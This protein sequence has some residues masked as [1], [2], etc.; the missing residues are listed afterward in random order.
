MSRSATVTQVD[1]EKA[2]DSI[3]W[4]FLFHALKKF[5][6]GEK[7]INWIKILYTD[8]QSCVGN[9]GFFSPFF[10]LTR[11]IRQGCPISALLFLLV[12]EVLAI[13]IRSDNNIKGIKINDVELKLS[14]MADD[15]TLFLADI[16][17]LTL[18]IHKFIEF[19]KCSGLKLNLNK[20]EIIPIGKSRKKDITLPDE[21]TTIQINHGPFKAL[22]IWYSYDQEEILKLNVDKRL[23]SMN[24]I[25][26]IWRSRNLSLKGK[27]T[28][29]KTLIIPQIHFLFAMIYIPDKI[30]QK[31]D[32]LLFDFLWNSKPAKIKR[33]TI[34]APIGEGGMGMV[35]V[36]IVHIASKIS[37]I[38]RLYDSTYGKWKIVMLKSM[39]TELNILNKKCDLNRNQNITKFY[40][41]VLKSWYEL[42]NYIPNSPN[43]ILNEYVLHNKSIKIGGKVIDKKYINSP[44]LKIIDITEKNG[45]KTL[46]QLNSTL[47]NN[48]TQMKYN[49]IISA[50][51][52]LWKRTIKNINDEDQLNIAIM[53]DEPHLKI[54]SKLKPL[55]KCNNKNI[56]LS[57]LI[58]NIKPP[59][60][61]DTWINIFPFL[62]KENWSAIYTRTFEITK[63]PYLQSFQFKIIN[64]ILNNNENLHRWKISKNNECYLC[65]EVDGIEH[66]LFLCEHSKKFWKSLN[67][68]MLEVFEFCVEFTV[69]EILFGLPTNYY[70]DTRRLNFLILLGKWY[71]N[72]NK[73]KQIPI[74]FFEYLTILKDKVN[75]MMYIPK[76]EGREVEPWLESLH[77]VL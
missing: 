47:E 75:T 43:E 23:K 68:W 12:A 71:I 21:L 44:N 53:N 5:N 18:S 69:C 42:F 17:S 13:N 27:I 64:R 52:V 2:F 55:S 36:Y 16:D 28:I 25:I 35:D 41:Q 6:F 46:I 61:T 76:I 45:F 77:D 29:I 54:N 26:N 62:E 39:N 37:W 32:K 33:T 3:E 74:H 38:K 72:K 20:T 8:I 7:F 19:E 49:S 58:K 56:Y 59:T 67:K 50:I 15:T 30:L 34:I 24:T 9:N 73:C 40:E 11:S 66:H 14:L 57:L 1:F 51:P 65:G 63:E 48:I 10:K 60:A 4:S 22:G 70:I 31:I